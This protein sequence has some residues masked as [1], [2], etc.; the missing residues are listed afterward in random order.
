M[1]SSLLLFLLSFLIFITTSKSTPATITIPLS[2]PSFTKLVV[3]SKDP[4]NALN[5]LATQSLSRS[6]HIKSPKTNFSNIKTPLF[7]RSYGGYSISLNFGT[8]PQTT[9]FVMD[10][11]SSLVWFPCTSR[12][13][14]AECNFP[15]IKRTG[16]P[17]FLP[18]LSSS[19][20]LIGCK[21]PRCSVFFGPEIQSKCH[22]CDSTAQNCTQTCPPYA[23]QYGS[24]STAG[25]L[26]SETLDFPNQKTIP[27]FLVGCSILST[28]Q[29]EGIAGFGRSPESL[30][31][32]LGLKKFSYCLVSHAFDDTPTSSDLVMHTGSGSSD[33]KT[34][35]LSYTPFQKNPTTAFRD[36]YY[37]FLRNI[38]IG[39]TH[40]KV[41]YK[42]L[43]PGSDG[44]GGTIVDSGTTFTFMEKPVYEVVAKEFEKQMAHYT[45]ATEIQ[46]LT[47]LRP[48]YNIS[49]EKSVSLP[50]LIFQFKGGAQMALPSSN[51][52]S[53]LD[54]GVICLTIVSDSIFGPGI[55]AGPA[56]IL[57]NYQQKNFYVEFDLEN[58]KFGFKPQSCV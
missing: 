49:G 21:N 57:G 43:V 41:P 13:L 54:S 36:Y 1:A 37:V 44:N 23:I 28:R 3:P 9:T 38:V 51:Y 24:G 33:T 40:V 17:T 11:G 26:L 50:D 20:K 27:D 22:E 15:D 8:P 19:S 16:I 2:A 7:P 48:C 53:F 14:C 6:H 46:N 29:P 45:V 10:S 32:Q 4:W 56:I 31:S 12:Y 5:H 47:G 42:F 25:L 58:E 30:P 34:P 35:G 39:D 18:K 52:F 55:G